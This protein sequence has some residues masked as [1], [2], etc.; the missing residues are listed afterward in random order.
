VATGDVTRMREVNIHVDMREGSSAV[1]YSAVQ[2]STVQYSAVQCSTVQYSAVQRST[3]QYSAV[4]CSTAQ[5]SAVQCSTVQY[6]AVQHSTVTVTLECYDALL[7]DMCARMT[8]R[9]A[10]LLA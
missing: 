10:S 5:Y 8:P 6:S 7:T 2:R 4:Q 9:A 1:Q 3:V